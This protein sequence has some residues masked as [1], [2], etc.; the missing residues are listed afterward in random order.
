MGKLAPTV[1]LFAFPNALK[2]RFCWLTALLKKI[3]QIF[4]KK[5]TKCLFLTELWGSETYKSENTIL[6]SR[7]F[8]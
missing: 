6:P 3:V 7:N 8:P 5:H 4:P 2:F 1:L